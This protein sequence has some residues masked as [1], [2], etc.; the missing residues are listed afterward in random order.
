MHREAQSRGGHFWETVAL[1]E[2]HLTL[3]IDSHRRPSAW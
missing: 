1:P 2:G 3:G